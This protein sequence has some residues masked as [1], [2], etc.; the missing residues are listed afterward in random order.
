MMKK[1]RMVLLFYQVVDVWEIIRIIF[2]HNKDSIKFVTNELKNIVSNFSN[3]EQ[4]IILF[5]DEMKVQEIWFGT[6][7]QVT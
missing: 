7:T 1:Q 2:D 5:M 3:I 6:N 4:Y